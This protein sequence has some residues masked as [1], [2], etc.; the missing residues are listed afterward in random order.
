MIGPGN[1][2]SASSSASEVKVKA[3][4]L[5]R[6]DCLNG[7]VTLQRGKAQP[8]SLAHHLAQMLV[9]RAQRVEIDQYIAVA[10]PDA[11]AFELVHAR[12]L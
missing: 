7:R 3:A 5:M 8:L 11:A 4:E 2:F 1:I 10:Q 12:R 9:G 6:I